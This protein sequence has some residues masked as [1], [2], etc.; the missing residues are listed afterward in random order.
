MRPKLRTDSGRGELLPMKHPQIRT[1]RS[2]ILSRMAP[3]A[4]HAG[5]PQT[6]GPMPCF[7]WLAYRF[8]SVSSASGSKSNHKL[9]SSPAASNRTRGF[10]RTFCAVCRDGGVAARAQDPCECVC[11]GRLVADPRSCRGMGS[12]AYRQLIQAL[13][14]PRSARLGNA[15]VWSL[16]SG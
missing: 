1:F 6:R 7:A 3:A 10:K 2:G 15:F 4:S 13:V 8:L 12:W 14:C 9:D 16:G 5:S 11:D